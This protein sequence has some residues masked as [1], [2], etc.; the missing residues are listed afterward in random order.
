MQLPPILR[1]YSPLCLYNVPLLL[2]S[3]SSLYFPLIIYRSIRRNVLVLHDFFFFFFFFFFY[4]GNTGGNNSSKMCV[5][6]D[7]AYLT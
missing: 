2:L 3:I 4:K 6:I 5:V 1:F 7:F